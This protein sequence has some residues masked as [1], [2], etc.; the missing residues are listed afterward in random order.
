LKA[1]FLFAGSANP[2]PWRGFAD[3]TRIP[4]TRRIRRIP[5]IPI[6]VFPAVAALAAAIAEVMNPERTL[7]MDWKGPFLA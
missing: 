7:P 3:P 2:T 1:V 6:S 4:G 5:Q